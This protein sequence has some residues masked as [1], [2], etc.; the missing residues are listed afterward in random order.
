MHLI[1]SDLWIKMHALRK[2]C[3]VKR[4]DNMLKS[5]LNWGGVQMVIHDKQLLS[6]L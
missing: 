4:L 3:V 6:F 2:T 5:Q 1:W